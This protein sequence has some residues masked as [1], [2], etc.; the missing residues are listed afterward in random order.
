MKKKTGGQ[1]IGRPRG[2]E[3]RRRDGKIS[4]KSVLNLKTPV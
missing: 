1:K 2:Y 4:K 3:K